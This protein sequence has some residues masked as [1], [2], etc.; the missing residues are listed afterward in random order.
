[1]H[2]RTPA[3]LFNYL[4]SLFYLVIPPR[5]V[6]RPVWDLRPGRLRN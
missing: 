4:Y 1:L 2:H 5:A 6:K 3:L